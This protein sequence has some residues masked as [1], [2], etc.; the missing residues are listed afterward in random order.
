MSTSLCWFWGDKFRTT[1][2]QQK[3]MLLEQTLVMV[4]VAMLAVFVFLQVEHDTSDSQCILLS[5]Q[6]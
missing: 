1:A 6:E 3:W 2:L 4:C 5:H